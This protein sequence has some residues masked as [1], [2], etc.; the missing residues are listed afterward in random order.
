[1][2]CLPPLNYIRSAKVAG[3]PFHKLG[4]R[5]KVFAGETRR[6]CLSRSTQALVRLMR[7]QNGR[8]WS[9]VCC[10]SYYAALLMLCCFVLPSL[11]KWDCVCVCLVFKAGWSLV[12]NACW[13]LTFL[14]CIRQLTCSSELTCS[15]R[16]LSRQKIIEER[17]T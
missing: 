10:A 8:I 7:P 5:V 17:F 13:L 3:K 1:M 9:E 16:P 2:S 12:W 14:S 4:T 15:N 6:S 11:L